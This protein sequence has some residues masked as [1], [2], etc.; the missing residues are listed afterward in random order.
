MRLRASSQ[1]HPARSSGCDCSR[2]RPR[3]T[4]FHLQRR[5]RQTDRLASSANRHLRESLPALANREESA[6]ACVSVE[7]I[8]KRRRFREPEAAGS[9]R[10]IYARGIGGL[11]EPGLRVSEHLFHALD[12]TSDVQPV[13]Q[14]V[15]YLDGKG[16]QRPAILLDEFA[17]RD[18]R[19]GVFPAPPPA[20]M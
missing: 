20:R 8:C 11:V 7:K 4:R 10:E 2:R 15:V 9:L 17:E 19:H 3:Y 14:R 18:F 5:R 12:V 13:H 6:A 1:F 16:H